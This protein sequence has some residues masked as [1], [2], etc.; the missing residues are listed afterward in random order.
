MSLD[1]YFVNPDLKETVRSGESIL[2]FMR[3]INRK[4]I[5][6]SWNRIHYVLVLLEFSSFTKYK[7]PPMTNVPKCIPGP[8]NSKDT[9]VSETERHF[10]CIA[11][12]KDCS[13]V[14]DY[15]H[16]ICYC[17]LCFWYMNSVIKVC[18]Q[19]ISYSKQCYVPEGTL[20]K[21]K[22]HLSS[23][24]TLFR[25]NM[26]KQSRCKSTEG[27][28]ISSSFPNGQWRG[29][30]QK[31]LCKSSCAFMAWDL[32]RKPHPGPWIYPNK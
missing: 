17:W 32:A 13:T 25:S 20:Q 9:A 24:Q 16:F 28:R 31:P 29:T 15:E 5:G 6:F 1:C 23:R 18:S 26:N 27:R 12:D 30:I 14:L 11:A 22:P 10:G 21:S 3:G 2:N 7:I 8:M 4:T 19:E